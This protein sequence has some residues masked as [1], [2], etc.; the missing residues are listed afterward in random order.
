MTR[1]EALEMLSEI[2]DKARDEDGYVNYAVV[3]RCEQLRTYILDSI[4][5]PKV[6]V[7]RDPSGSGI[8]YV[9]ENGM[10]LVINYAE[11][12]AERYADNLRAALGIG[13]Q[14]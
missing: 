5:T 14:P 10:V 4:P 11:E 1:D 13:A 3:D 12:Y 6:E 7:E 9:K 2:P 8:W